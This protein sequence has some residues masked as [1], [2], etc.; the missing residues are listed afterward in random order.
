MCLAIEVLCYLVNLLG[1]NLLYPPP[2]LRK[3]RLV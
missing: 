3:H 2:P 1:M